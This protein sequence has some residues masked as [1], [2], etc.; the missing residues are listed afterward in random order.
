V[1]RRKA[2]L[3]F[4]DGAGGRGV[5][6]FLFGPGLHLETGGG[7]VTKKRK[8]RVLS[9]WRNTTH[10]ANS[11]VAASP[12]LLT[13]LPPP[14]QTARAATPFPSSSSPPRARSP[15]RRDSSEPAARRDG[16]IRGNHSVPR[17]PRSYHQSRVSR[18][19]FSGGLVGL[20][21]GS[22]GASADCLPARLRGF[23]RW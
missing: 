18:G 22:G 8:A 23:E 17:F 13:P 15:R 19:S 14:H 3:V 6:G 5:A 1:R 9:R 10:D 16:E 4:G 21:I 7:P 12:Y 2:P 20:G 11:L